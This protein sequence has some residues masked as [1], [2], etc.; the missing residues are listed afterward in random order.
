MTSLFLTRFGSGKASFARPFHETLRFL[1]SSNVT[2]S[3]V[4]TNTTTSP[5]TT[6]ED[7]SSS[8]SSSSSKITKEQK[9]A[10][11]RE[12]SAMPPMNIFDAL[13]K[14]REAMW[15]KFDETIEMAVVT[16]LDPRK[17]NQSV[18]GIAQLPHGNGKSVR[19]AVFAEGNDAKDA[20]D[21][22]ADLV[23]SDDLIKKI[24]AGEIDFQRCI[25]TP[26]MMGSVSRIGKLLGPKGLMP[27]PKLGTVTKD[28][29]RAIKEA[30]AGSVQFKV[31]RKG[32][33]M[34]GIGKASFSDEMIL[35]NIKSFMVALSDYK[36]EGFKGKYFKRVH[37]TSSMGPGLELDVSSVDPSNSR[38]MVDPKKL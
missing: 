16:S 38:F 10:M 2:T 28:V 32:I 27:N 11:K 21:A 25:A 7:P 23:G 36:P 18:K 5:E 12:F 13:P 33:I 26:D 22:G 8:S 30:K 3:S 19:V 24:Q 34:A 31:E 29:V 37:V 35:E 20:E 17:P 6:S 9:L 15:A 4:N 1:C 14:L